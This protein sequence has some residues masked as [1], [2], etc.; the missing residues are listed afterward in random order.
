MAGDV[1][2]NTRALSGG[3][4][5]LVVIDEK[6]VQEH[7]E[8]ESAIATTSFAP[9]QDIMGERISFSDPKFSARGIIEYGRSPSLSNSEDRTVKMEQ[10]Q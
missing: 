9:P 3:G 6:E 8:E 7:A 5:S 2:P 10:Q 4:S 1:L